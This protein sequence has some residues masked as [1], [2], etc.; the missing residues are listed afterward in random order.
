MLDCKTDYDAALHQMPFIGEKND[1]PD[2]GESERDI[3]DLGQEFLY[4]T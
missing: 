4:L 2:T 3:I 1:L